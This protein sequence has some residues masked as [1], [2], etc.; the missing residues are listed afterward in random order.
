MLFCCSLSHILI[1][2]LEKVTFLS[3]VFDALGLIVYQLAVL[4]RE[5]PGSRVPLSRICIV[6]DNLDVLDKQTIK[7]LSF[8]CIYTACL[9]YAE[10]F[11]CS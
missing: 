2:F 6:V 5:K 3:I 11:Y 1:V 10:V 8:E 4:C 7:G 9:I